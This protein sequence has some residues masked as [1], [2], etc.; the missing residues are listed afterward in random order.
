MVSI[1]TISALIAAPSVAL[2]QDDLSGTLTIS[3]WE[4]TEG[5][6]ADNVKA[7][8][9]QYEAAR[10]GVTVEFQATSYND[11]PTTIKTQI[12]AG[13]GPDV[14]VLLDQDF[15]QLQQAG[16][17][18]PLTSLTDEQIATL[19]PANETAVFDGAA[20]RLHLGDRDLR[21][22]L[23]QGP[24][25]AGRDRGAADRLRWAARGLQGDQ[26]QDRQVGLRRPQHDQ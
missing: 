3:D 26:G 15:F 10:P 14:M 6:F 22:P 21:L 8:L 19:R 7:V 13:G 2:A 12:G 5:T 23:Q 20:V 11:Y 16:A 18:A 17:L 1:L 9:K 25:P 4:F 24:L